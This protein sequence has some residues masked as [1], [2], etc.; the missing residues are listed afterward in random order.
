MPITLRDISKLK[1]NIA[2]IC[3]FVG[4]CCG[5]A[6]GTVLFKKYTYGAL[7]GD[8]HNVRI[9]KITENDDDYVTFLTGKK[10]DKKENDIELFVTLNTRTIGNKVLA[11]TTF[12]NKSYYD[13]Y[14]FI[15]NIPYNRDV[16][17][18]N[19]FHSLCE[20][21]FSIFTDDYI[22]LDFL[23]EGCLPENMEIDSWVKIAPQKEM[24]FTVI[25]NGSYLFL[26]GEHNYRIKTAD[27]LVVDEKWFV[28]EKINKKLFSIVDFN[29]PKCKLNKY[30]Y[31]F[32]KE[33]E[34]CETDP[35]AEDSI[36]YFMNFYFPGGDENFSFHKINSNQVSIKIN[37]NKL[38]SFYDTPRGLR[39]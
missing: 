21:M 19:Y 16:K 17:Y 36:E 31:F 26:A 29:Y 33:A 24:T 30:S 38:K 4:L 11:S 32:Q 28:T 14:V 27:Y 3:F 7:I 6:N 23:G 15:T 20:D 12:K 10:T 2:C 9:S 1:F 8:H 34:L 13:R 5:H 39:S 22:K 35:W 18:P 37:G 25:L